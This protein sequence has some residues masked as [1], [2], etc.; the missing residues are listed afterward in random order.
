MKLEC[1]NIQTVEPI[2][3]SILS[4]SDDVCHVN[5]GQPIAIGD[6]TLVDIDVLIFV[7]C[8]K[9]LIMGMVPN[10][11]WNFLRFLLIVL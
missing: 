4:V 5:G 3:P 10:F 1:L 9:T 6:V 8:S 11:A 2:D 7:C